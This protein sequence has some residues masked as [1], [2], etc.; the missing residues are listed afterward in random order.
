MID[1]FTEID[2]SPMAQN[3]LKILFDAEQGDIRLAVEDTL[4][5]IPVFDGPEFSSCPFEVDDPAFAPLRYV[6]PDID[7][8]RGPA[9]LVSDDHPLQI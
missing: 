3:E 6:V 4:C 9:I 2:E 8:F 7:H 5:I 1:P